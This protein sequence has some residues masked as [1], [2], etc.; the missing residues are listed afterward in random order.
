MHQRILVINIGGTS[1]P[2]IRSIRESKPDFLLMIPSATSKRE[3]DPILHAAYPDGG[4]P[5]TEYFVIDNPNDIVS[6]FVQC[7]RAFE[8]VRRH[9]TD[10]T[11]VL[12]DPT[13]GTK[14]MSAALVLA[15]AELGVQMVYIAGE[16]TKEGLGVVM[17]GTEMTVYSTHPYD[18]IA[19]TDKLRFC[20][21]FNSYRFSS[22]KDVSSEIISRSSGQLQKLFKTLRLI[23]EAYEKWDLFNYKPAKHQ[24][25]SAYNNL[26]RLIEERETTGRRLKPFS[27]AVESN[28]QHL[29]GLPNDK[30]SMEMVDELVANAKR[31]ASEGKYDDAVARLYRALEM[32][33]QVRFMNIFGVGTK[34]FPLSKLS[35]EIGKQFFRGKRDDAIEDIGCMTAYKVLEALGDEYGL[36]FAKHREEVKSIL[37]LRNDSILAHGNRPMKEGD[38]VKLSSV[39]EKALGIESS[40]EFAKIDF[41]D[42][43]SIGIGD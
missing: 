16:R 2:I 7:R 21:Y 36:V 22:A 40:V 35:A 18:L 19:R 12:A 8:F 33:A 6:C 27:E 26:T 43:E 3:I 28:L 34:K 41:E 39:F 10:D 30:F 42:I 14:I 13:G 11:E 15:A 23:C 29:L 31:R 25:K 9:S 17:N 20:Q 37:N 38:Y 4:K 1:A 5:K 24:M 32:I